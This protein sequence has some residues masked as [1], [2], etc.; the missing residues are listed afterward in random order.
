MISLVVRNEASGNYSLV[1]LTAAGPTVDLTANTIVNV[2]NN[3]PSIIPANNPALRVYNYKTKFNRDFGALTDY[4]Q[5]YTDLNAD[6]KAGNVTWQTEYRA[7]KEY[8]LKGLSV[9]DY[10]GLVKGFQQPG[11][12]TWNSYVSFIYV[13]TKN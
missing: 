5:Y 2:L 1:P 9:K 11:S 7:S 12:T 4:V 10:T 3:A 8:G 6:N 13:G